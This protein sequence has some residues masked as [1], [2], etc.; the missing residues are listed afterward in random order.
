MKIATPEYRYQHLGTVYRLIEQFELISR[1]DLAKLSGLAPA[2]MTALTKL[3]IE[4]QFIIERTSQNLASRGRPAVGLIVSPFY[5]SILCITLSSSKFAISLC[6]LD[7]TVKYSHDYPISKSDYANLD[8]KI[9][10]HLA[11]F[12]AKQPFDFQSL[13]AISVSV[14]GKLSQNNES[15]IQLGIT[16][17]QCELKAL[18]E[19]KFTQPILINEHFRLWFL[20]ESTLG[21]LISNT[22]AIYFQL[23]NEINL[24]VLLKGKLLNQDEHKRMSVDKMLMPKFAFSD[25]IAPELPVPERYQLKNQISLEMLARLIDRY[26]PNNF[27]RLPEKI[28]HFCNEVLAKNATAEKILEH[29]TDNLAYMLMN[30]INL[31]SC[32]KVMFNSPLVQIK[33]PLF[34]QLQRKLEKQL[35]L[36]DLK[37]DLVTSQY[38]WDNP[39]IPAIAIKLA[40][41]DGEM[42]KNTISLKSR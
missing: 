14:L 25:E 34:A 4:H 40:I 35:L 38:D 32:E 27:E 39:Q 2:S 1:T 5:W 12:I 37:I 7:G 31:F 21:N 26:L 33:Q 41:Y 9:T 16:P 22:D 29:L 23:D 42:L 30:L 17:V 20:T 36:D 13:F 3:L 19:Q 15:V 24:S 11:H 10:Q 8:E 18:L 28:T 6:L